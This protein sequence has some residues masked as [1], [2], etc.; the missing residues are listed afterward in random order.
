MSLNEIIVRH[1]VQP[2]IDKPTAKDMNL[3]FY[4]DTP[5][6]YENDEDA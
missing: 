4:V 6:N 1:N 3:R 5:N 2:K